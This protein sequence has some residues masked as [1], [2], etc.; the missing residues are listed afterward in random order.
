MDNRRLQ[1]INSD[2]YRIIATF[3]AERG[4][5]AEVTD[6]QTAA[7]LSEAK[8]FVSAELETLE[9]AAGFLRGEIARRLNLRHTP[10]I[11]FIKDRGH[12]NAERVEEL[13]EQIKG[14]IK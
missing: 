12:E 5:R 14:K 6:V 8:V 10:K 3:I 9:N 1:R 13:L 11:K 2:I 7:D 4:V